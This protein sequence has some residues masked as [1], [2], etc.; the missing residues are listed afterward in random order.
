MDEFPNQRGFPPFRAVVELVGPDAKLRRLAMRTFPDGFLPGTHES[1]REFVG[2]SVGPRPE[3]VS[4]ECEGRRVVAVLRQLLLHERMHR[5]LSH[6]AHSRHHP[7]LHLPPAA[8]FA[9]LQSR[10]GTVSSS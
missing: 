2:L 1:K 4:N 6:S 8:I 9:V 3:F 5:K 10:T 7:A